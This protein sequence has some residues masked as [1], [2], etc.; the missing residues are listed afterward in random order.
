[1]LG[2]RT[3]T[4]ERLR[5]Q[6]TWLRGETTGRTALLLSFA[7]GGQP[8]EPGPTPGTRFEAELVFY[9]GAHPQRALVRERTGTPETINVLPGVE[10]LDDALGEWSAALCRNPWTERVA[11]ALGGVTPVRDGGRWLLRDSAGAALPLPRAAEEAAWV[12][13]AAGGGRPVQVAAEWDG[14]ALAP[15]G[16][17]VD[18]RYLVLPT[19]D[20]A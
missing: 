4:E 19:G 6:R 12:L 3:E 2:T 11:F 15:L 18:G 8:L 16:A 17:V 1:V 7:A 10:S 20:A 5:V 13:L 9:P 14:A